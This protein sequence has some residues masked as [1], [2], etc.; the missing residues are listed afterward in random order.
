MKFILRILVAAAAIFGVAYLTG[1]SLLTV[2][3]FWPTAV[4]AALVLG[5]ANAVIKPIVHVLAFPITF[6]TLGLFALVINA[7]MLYLVAAIVPGFDTVGFFQTVLAALLIAIV[8][9][10]VGK[11]LEK[12]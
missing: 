4:I 9:G 1:G 11:M 6:L 2:D 3:E 5:I 10:V 8:T 12:D 7:G